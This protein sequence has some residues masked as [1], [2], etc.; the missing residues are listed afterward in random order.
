MTKTEF[1]ETLRIQLSGQIQ[2]G[3]A[4]AHVRYYRDYIEEQTGRGRSEEEVLAELGDPRLIAKTL[5]DTDPESGQGI[6][7]SSGSGYG[8][9]G[10]DSRVY[11]DAGYG[12]QED[13][14]NRQGHVKHH[15]YRLDLTTWYGKAIVIAIAAAVIIGLIILIGTVL[16]VIIIAGLI[17]TLI[18]W[19]RRR[20]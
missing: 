15:S 19:I 8:S 20:S 2:A 4:E 11:E 7:E 9:Q 14:G 3:K 10:Y 6:Y 13:S 1:L 5:L 18:S 12:S 17:L 16:P